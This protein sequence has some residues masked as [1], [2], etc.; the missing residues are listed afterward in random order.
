MIQHSDFVSDRTLS[1]PEGRAVRLS[2]FCGEGK[3]LHVTKRDGSLSAWCHRCCESGRYTATLS[4]SEK[5]EQLANLKVMEDTVLRYRTLPKDIDYVLANWPA[6]A[7]L[8]LYKCGFTSQDIVDLQASYS[9]SIGRVCVPLADGYIARA[10]HDGQSPKYLMVA[11][12]RFVSYGV[13][14]SSVVLTEDALSAYKVATRG[15]IEAIPLMGTYLKPSLEAYL[16]TKSEVILWLDPDRGGY[17]GTA[18]IRRSLS[19]ITKV[20]KVVSERD[21]KYSCKAQIIGALCRKQLI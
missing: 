7:K 9:P 16:A 14:S 18:R 10:V 6:K 17:V 12:T 19:L 4:L 20:F 2:H 1:L 15:D 13:Q 11:P 8:W 21:P 3:P 5:L